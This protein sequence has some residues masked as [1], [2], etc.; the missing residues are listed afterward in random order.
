MFK[1]I[2]NNNFLEGTWNL[3][4]YLFVISVTFLLFS[5]LEVH[6]NQNKKLKLIS[7]YNFLL[8]LWRIIIIFFLNRLLSRKIYAIKTL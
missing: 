2:Q 1:N 6:F 4:F 8:I 7:R 3:K 5:V